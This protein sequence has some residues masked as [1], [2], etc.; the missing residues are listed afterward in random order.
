M[1]FHEMRQFFQLFAIKFI[2][3]K[4]DGSFFENLQFLAK[5]MISR[6]FSRNEA[7]FATSC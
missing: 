1:L 6:A 2:E 7:L 4:K 5:S 3:T